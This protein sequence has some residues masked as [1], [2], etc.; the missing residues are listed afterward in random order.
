MQRTRGNLR[1]REST[2]RT[3]VCPVP[4]L[5][6]VDPSACVIANPARWVD[7]PC[8][9]LRPRIAEPGGPRLFEQSS[10]AI[11]HLQSFPSRG[12]ATFKTKQPIVGCSCAPAELEYHPLTGVCYLQNKTAHCGLFVRPR[13]NSNTTPSRGSVTFKTKQP[14]VGCS[15]APGRTR[16]C[17]L[18][19]RKQTLYPIELRGQATKIIPRSSESSRGVKPSAGKRAAT[20]GKRERPSSGN[21]AERAITPSC[22]AIKH[23][24]IFPPYPIC[25]LVLRKRHLSV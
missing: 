11:T 13:Q 25:K 17:N 8:F 4:P 1:P 3:R 19:L 10:A 7:G 20:T 6:L 24:R 5:T 2:A 9:Y 15:C 21:G 14:I 12:S 22:C 18:L 23:I 16:I